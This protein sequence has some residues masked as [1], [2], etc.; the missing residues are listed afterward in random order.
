MKKLVVHILVVVLV[1]VLAM[2]A[3]STERELFSPDDV[4]V[5][6]VDAMLYVDW[7]FP[8][9]VLYRAQSAEAPFNAFSAAERGAT[10][11]VTTGSTTTTY[12]EVLPGVYQPSGLIPTVEPETTYM[13][14]V[15]STAGERLTAFTTTPPRLRVPDWV[16]L[17]DDATTVDRRLRNFEEI[18]DSVY[19]APENQLIHTE[20][21]LEA[22]L[23]P[24]VAAGYQAGIYALDPDSGF[25]IDPEFLEDEDFEDFEPNIASP[26]IVNSQTEIRLPWFAIYYKGRYKIKIFA[27][28]ENWF[29]LA[30]TVPE[31]AG[32]GGGFGGNAGDNF[33]RPIF[34]VTG[35]IGIFG[36]ASMDS[37]GFY[38]HPRP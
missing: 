28:D 9:I 8:A 1:V 35:G 22:W 11:A 6:G 7:P 23:A 32:G 17:N 12:V 4:D 19:T 24:V 10:V 14:E 33:E 20:G 37:V 3:C 31:L 13:L 16:L 15:T 21:L 18:G 38:V 25:V 5:L 2:L 27:V 26:P 34:H 30:R 36:S 29:D